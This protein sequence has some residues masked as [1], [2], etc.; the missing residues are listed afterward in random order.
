[1][2]DDSDYK[3]DHDLTDWATLPFIGQ[4]RILQ[5]AEIKLQG[6]CVLLC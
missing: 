2:T 1:M 6:T 4:G 3:S 5:L